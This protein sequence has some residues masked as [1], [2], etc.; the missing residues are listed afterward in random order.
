[1]AERKV[2][3]NKMFELMR[4]GYPS[5]HPEVK[6]LDLRQKILKL[7][8]N[9]YYGAMS[10]KGF[11]FYNE[12]M[13]PAITYTGQLIIAATMTS[14]EAFLSNNLW[15]RNANQLATHIFSSI[16]KANGRLPSE[17][18]GN[19]PLAETV[20]KE[21]VIEHLLDACAP[22]WDALT[23]I[24][25]YIDTLSQEDLWA[26]YL[27]GNPYFFLQFE[28][29]QDLLTTSLS[30]EIREADPGKIAKHHPEGK[31]ALDTLSVGML[32]WVA[33]HWQHFDMP[34]VVAE[35]ERRS[36]ILVDTDSNFLGLDP[37]MNYLGEAYDLSEATEDELLTGLNVMVYLLRLVNDHYM[38]LLTKNLQI[39]EDKRYLINFKSEFVIARMILTNG[40]KNYAA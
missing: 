13:G 5:D 18:W 4:N 7:L 23:A 17:E 31:V 30:G 37:W 38:A 33:V 40:K 11:I 14:F 34:R 35:M 1:M 6:A 25:S 26:L 15:I 28:K 19:H 36:V 10:E 20:T 27:K 2:A 3:K 12:N 21:A 24:H 32:D 39:Q 9:S 8:A 22:N 29:A 16:E